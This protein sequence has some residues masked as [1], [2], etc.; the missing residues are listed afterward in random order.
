MNC[1]GCQKKL[2]KKHSEAYK[3]F[4][5][6]ANP[7]CSIITVIVT[8]TI[9]DQQYLERESDGNGHCACDLTEEARYAVKVLYET[10]CEFCKVD[11]E[12]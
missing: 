2:I 8:T 6:C 10:Y 11:D 1:P 4:Y 3:S 7:E 9:K 12:R 5:L